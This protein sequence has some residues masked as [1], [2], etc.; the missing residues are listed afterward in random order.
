MKKILIGSIGFLLLTGGQALSLPLIDG[1]N[2]GDENTITANSNTYT[3]V[4][5]RQDSD[6]WNIDGYLSSNGVDTDFTGL[7]L[8]TIKAPNDSET[9]LTNLLNFYL[10]ATDTYSFIKVDVEE[11]DVSPNSNGY[12]SVTFSADLKTGTWTLSGNLETTFYSVKGGTGYALYYVN[13]GQATGEW[14][15]AH[16]LNNG[17]NIP[18]ISHLTAQTQPIP[19]P[20]AMLLLGSGLAGLAMIGRRRKAKA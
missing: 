19:E 8:G 11:E 7:Y 15:T 1:L 9:D 14:T 10:N 3:V 16:L 5:Y 13:P 20:T 17:G 12:L 18:A 6:M 4:N 2:Y